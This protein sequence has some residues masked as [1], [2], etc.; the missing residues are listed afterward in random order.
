MKLLADSIR[1]P[2]LV[3]RGAGAHRLGGTDWPRQ[4]VDPLPFLDGFHLLFRCM[5]DSG[6][7]QTTSASPSLYVR[8]R[9]VSA[10]VRLVRQLS[11]VAEEARA[12]HPGLMPQTHKARLRP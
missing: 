11:Y 2:C 6:R 10:L 4:K 12:R 9:N 5:P 1:P 7:H 8:G 3:D